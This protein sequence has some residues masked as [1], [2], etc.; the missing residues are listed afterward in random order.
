MIALGQATRRPLA[1][2]LVLCAAA[3]SDS[4]PTE[5]VVRIASD[6]RIPDEIDGLVVKV[7]HW[8]ALRFD[9]TYDLD[10]RTPGFVTLPATVGI[11]AGE[12]PQQPVRVVASAM[13]HGALV[14]ERRAQ[15]AFLE[16][17]IL[18]LE[19]LL[20]R[21]CVGVGCNLDQTCANGECRSMEEDPR[22]LPEHTADGV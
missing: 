9:Q 16:Q 6:L 3:C 13:R 11:V 10:P 1:A 8:G 7:E 18:L 2:L 5:I 12:T 15:L 19:M 4:Q 22:R 20:S 14:V 17:R 21:S